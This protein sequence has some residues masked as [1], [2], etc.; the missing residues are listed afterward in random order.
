[1]FAK[2]L[3]RAIKIFVITSAIVFTLLNAPLFYTEGKYFLAQIGS[4][5]KTE[6]VHAS[7]KIQPVKLPVSEKPEQPVLSN[8]A[9]LV[10]DKI[11]VNVPI[12]FGIDGDNFDA[13]YDNLSNGVVHF[14]E[15]VKP[16]LMGTS[17]ILGHSSDFIWKR[18]RYARVFALLDKLQ[19]GDSFAVKYSDGK[20][21]TFKVTE[22]FVFDPTKDN[23][24]KLT[25][26]ESS[27]KPV[28]LLETCWPVTS[29]ALRRVVRAE[30]F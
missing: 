12:V 13:I 28:L 25:S 9:T 24:A 1:M 22:S 21:F 15:T 26:L 20:V 19:P 27:Q 14:S 6:K 10:I 23:E 2:K 5:S 17:M 7:A 8:Q 29:T 30:V 11:G 18:N 4:T 3:I 16:G